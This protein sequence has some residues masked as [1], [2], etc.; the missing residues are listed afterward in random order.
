MVDLV[1]MVES[2]RLVRILLD[3][4]PLSTRDV[5]KEAGC[6]ERAADYRLR[7]L[8]ADGRIESARIGTTHRWWVPR[9]EY[10]HSPRTSA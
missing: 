3:H 5:A 1:C 9:K 7:K 2:E 6:S 8:Y 10:E 4:G